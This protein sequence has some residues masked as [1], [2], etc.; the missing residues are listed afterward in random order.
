MTHINNPFETLLGQQQCIILDG[1]LATE[2]EA[3]GHD[4]SSELW[5]ALLLRDKPQAI[6]DAHRAFF[7]SGANCTISASYQGTRSGLMSLGLSAREAKDLIIKSVQLAATAREGFLQDR[8]HEGIYPLVAASIGP[9]GASLADGSEYTGDYGIDDQALANFHRERLQWLDGS[10]ADVLACETIPSL[11]EARVL[12][13]LL[14]QVNSPAWVSFSCRDGKHLNDG[15]PIQTCARLFSGHPR[16]KAIGV[17]CTSPKYINSLIQEIKAVTPEQNVVVYPNSG[18]TY[19]ADD[20]C[21]YGTASPLECGVAA[22][23]WRDSGAIIIGG[24]CRMG[25]DHIREIQQHLV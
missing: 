16:V 15:T 20:K 24:C 22:R 8:G 18:E 17:N 21:W 5:S 9:Y 1:G 23:T 3:Q 4:L 13:D 2:L 11:Q 12:H 7:E 25:P 19:N 6:I 14:N 10:G